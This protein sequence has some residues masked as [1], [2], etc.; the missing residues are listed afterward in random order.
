MRVRRSLFTVVGLVAMVGG[1]A[2]SP[3]IAASPMPGGVVTIMFGRGS[4]HLTN[5]QCVVLPGSVN[6]YTVAKDLRSRNLVATLPMTVSQ[7]GTGPARV[8]SSGNLY[9]NWTDLANFRDHYR[10]TVVPRGLTNADLT[11]VKDP[12]ALEA[13]ICGALRPFREHGHHRA[14]GMFAWPQNRFTV[15]YQQRYVTP[16]YAF[17]RRYTGL[18]GTNYL[19]IPYPYWVR[20]VSV[21]GGKCADVTLPCHTFTFREGYDYMQPNALAATVAMAAKNGSW[22]LLQFYSLVWGAY[23]RMGDHFAWDC[24]SP[25]PADHWSSYTEYYCWN[26]YQK[27]ISSIPSSV[28][29]TDPATVAELIGRDPPR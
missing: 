9:A 15:E 23:G 17:G 16:C 8:C 14:W 4:I 27:V 21:N 24:R 25:D 19:P 6:L 2:P 22:T 10:W 28:R 5:Y 18:Y 12:A 1:P 7:I 29:V 20:V 11:A 3:G 13:N 26:D